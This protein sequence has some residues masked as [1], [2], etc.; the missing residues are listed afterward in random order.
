MNPRKLLFVLPLLPSAAIILRGMVR[1]TLGSK[2][3]R[4]VLVLGTAQYNGVPSR[5]FA[6]RL[7]WT[8]RLWR[9]RRTMSVITVGGKLPADAQ[10]EAEVGREYLVK[11]HVDPDVIT[12]VAAGVDTWESFEQ[13]HPFLKEPVLVVTDPNHALR[14]ELMARMHGIKA[15]ASPTPYSP[16]KFPSKSWWLS[17]AHEHGGLAVVALTAVAG[18]PVSLKLEGFLRNL[19]GKIRPNRRARHEF[20][21]QRSARLAQSHR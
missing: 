6:A 15:V 17:L 3:Y 7:Q 19:E 13:A 1:P 12:M 14:S 20:L 11:A 5:Q 2:K 9:A 21:A 16:S 18:R 8:E 4:S 10:Y